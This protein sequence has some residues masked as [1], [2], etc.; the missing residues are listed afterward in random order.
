M[1]TVR[2]RGSGRDQAVS[3]GFRRLR[4]VKSSRR[5][6]RSAR[7]SSTSSS[8]RSSTSRHLARGAGDGR[9]RSAHCAPDPTRRVQPD[10]GAGGRDH[11]LA[12]GA[13][14]RRCM[15]IA[16]APAVAARVHLF[17][18]TRRWYPPTLRWPWPS[19]LFT[20]LSVRPSVKRCGMGVRWGVVRGTVADSALC[21]TLRKLSHSRSEFA[22]G[23]G[24][25]SSGRRMR[26]TSSEWDENVRGR[27]PGV[28]LWKGSGEFRRCGER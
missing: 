20:S 27:S 10:C 24:R 16:P 18:S 13:R 6:S 17:G 12:G 4:C 5:S 26:R 14:R 2:G 25:D 15:R 28:E 21:G 8:K 19:S 7:T 23:A 1:A 3:C 22:T 9:A 11:T